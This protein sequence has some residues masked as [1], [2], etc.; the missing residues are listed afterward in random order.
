MIAQRK[1]NEDFIR[2]QEGIV[3][4]CLKAKKLEDSGDYEKAAEVLGELWIG[5]G[6]KPNRRSRRA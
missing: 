6:E 3:R 1:K 5:N 2:D 4:A